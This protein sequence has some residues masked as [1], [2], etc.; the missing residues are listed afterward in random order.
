MVIRCIWAIKQV[1]INLREFKSYTNMIT[2][3][4]GISF[5]FHQSEKSINE[6]YRA[7]LFNIWKL[8]NI[9]LNNPKFKEEIRREIIKYF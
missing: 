9:L 5:L 3:E 2:D 7:N 4:N 1:S 6:R 8:S